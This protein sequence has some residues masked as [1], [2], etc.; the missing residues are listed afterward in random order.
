MHNKISYYTLKFFI[1][2]P[3]N[4]VI[5]AVSSKTPDTYTTSDWKQIP[6]NTA[7]ES[8]VAP[9]FTKYSTTLSTVV[10]NIAILFTNFS[11][12]QRH[13]GK[14]KQ[15]ETFEKICAIVN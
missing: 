11:V 8:C 5:F 4:I 14:T 13:K 6:V 10:S 2:Q 3:S 9:P 15:I 1:L 7:T 12:Y